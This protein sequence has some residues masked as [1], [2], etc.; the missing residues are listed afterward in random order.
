VDRER[1][2]ERRGRDGERREGVQERQRGGERK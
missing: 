1:G 2:E